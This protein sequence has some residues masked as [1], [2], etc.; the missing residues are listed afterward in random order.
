MDSLARSWHSGTFLL[1]LLWA[2]PAQSRKSLRVGIGPLHMQNREPALRN[3][4]MAQWHQTDN[5]VVGLGYP[6]KIEFEILLSSIRNF[7]QKLRILVTYVRLNHEC[8]IL[9]FLIIATPSSWHFLGFNLYQLL[10][11]KTTWAELWMFI[12]MW[13]WTVRP[14]GKFGTC[15]FRYFVQHKKTSSFINEWKL[16]TVTHILAR[17]IY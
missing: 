5:P 12:T 6:F 10:C 11:P 7:Y 4:R 14:S 9:C 17:T 16:Y 1:G 13:K 3:S 8:F 2:G 15:P